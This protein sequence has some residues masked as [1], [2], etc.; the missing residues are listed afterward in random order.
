MGEISANYII[1]I[2]AILTEAR[3]QAYK[4]INMAMVNAY[5]KIGQR[6]VLEEQNGKERAEWQ[7]NHKKLI[8][9]PYS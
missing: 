6:I 4:A 1:E 7:R 3:S 8:W 5:W 9:S 2:K